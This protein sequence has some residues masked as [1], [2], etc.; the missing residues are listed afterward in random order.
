MA[1]VKVVCCFVLFCVVLC[2]VEMFLFG[3]G[4]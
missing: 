1:A 2:G 4:D 3:V